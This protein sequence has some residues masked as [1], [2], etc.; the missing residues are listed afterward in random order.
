MASAS[1]IAIAASVA[2][3]PSTAMAIPPCTIHTVCQCQRNHPP[4]PCIPLHP[5]RCSITSAIPTHATRLAN[6]DIGNIG[7]IGNIRLGNI[8]T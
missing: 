7:N 6:I 3:G 8:G 1:V 4:L 2:P 5:L